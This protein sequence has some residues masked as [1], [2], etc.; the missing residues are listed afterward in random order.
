MYLRTREAHGEYETAKVDLKKLVPE[1]AQ[2]ATGHGMKARRSKS[3]AIS[4][5]PHLLE[6]PH[7]PV[8]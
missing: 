2:E 4:F 8:Q 3:S 7:A 1:E 6:A 5:E